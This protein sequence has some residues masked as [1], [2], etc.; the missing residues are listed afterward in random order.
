MREANLSKLWLVWSIQTEAALSSCHL[1]LVFFSF[2][3]T[4]RLSFLIL[5]FSGASY[6]LCFFPA[7]VTSIVVV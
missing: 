2:F 6:D 7:P 4:S 3:T 5:S 1:G